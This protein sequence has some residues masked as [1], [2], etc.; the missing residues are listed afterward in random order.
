MPYNAEISRSNPSCF[1][2]LLD[3]SHSMNEEFVTS[4]GRRT[5]AE[6][7]ADVIN[8]SL[9]TLVAKCTKSSGIFDYYYVGV[10]G[11]SGLGVKSALSGGPLEG[12]DIVPISLIGN[13]PARVERKIK[14]IPDGKGGFLEKKMSSP[15]WVE[16]A[17]SGVT[18]MC[19]AFRQAHRIVQKFLTEH[20]TCFPPI[21]INIT[22][23]EA[24]DGDPREVGRKLMELTSSDGNVLLFNLHISSF[25]KN[26][27]QFPNSADEL[28]RDDDYAKELFSIS[29]PLTSYM[30]K[31]IS[32][33]G[34]T[35]RPQARGFAFNA[36][37]G[38]LLKFVEIGTRPKD[39]GVVSQELNQLFP[40]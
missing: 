13:Y 28:P 16:P 14:K 35:V 6:A 17:Y 26:T 40:S 25:S 18:P 10:I 15:V 7:V 12:K 22:D 34:G 36:D 38:S 3:Q 9:Q 19:E 31:V 24:S 37:F 5:K 11:Y 21:I 30:I 27:I 2:F 32:D 39:L 23:G 20:P 29:S 8:R 33:E 1:L 4:D